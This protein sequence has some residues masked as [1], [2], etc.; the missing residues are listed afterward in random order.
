MPD[1]ILP[2]DGVIVGRKRLFKDVW[3]AAK[4][5]GIVAGLFVLPQSIATVSSVERAKEDMVKYVDARHDDVRSQLIEIRE[6][7]KL[8]DAKIYE[9][10]REIKRGK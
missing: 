7:Q 6:A 4:V 3:T 8:T 2:I 5:I 10:L 9:I 1:D